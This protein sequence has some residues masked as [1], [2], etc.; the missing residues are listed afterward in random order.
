M[1]FPDFDR[2]RQLA[3]QGNFIPVYQ[4][5]VADLETPVSAW[6]KVCADQAY[7]FLLESVEGGETLGRYSF[8]GGDPVWVLEARGNTTT[9]TFRNGSQEIFSGDPFEILTQCLAPIVPVKL[10]Q[11]PAN[12]G[13]IWF[14]GL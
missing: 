5:W 7:N 13:F 3:G 1:I 6:Y 11:L 10:P 4:E 2:F 8:L 14:L 9:Q 12:R